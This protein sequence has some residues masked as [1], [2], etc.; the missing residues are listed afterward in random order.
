MILVTL[1]VKRGI[2]SNYKKR[3]GQTDRGRETETLWE[4]ISLPVLAVPG[5]PSGAATS[6]CPSVP[7]LSVVLLQAQGEG[8][9]EEEERKRRGLRM[10]HKTHKSCTKL[11]A[12]R[13]KQGCFPEAAASDWLHQRCVCWCV[14][15]GGWGVQDQAYMRTSLQMTAVSP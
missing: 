13:Y 10:T 1:L 9:R 15:R 11:I 3:E 7:R 8:K 6:L 14:C 5:Q 4:V 12:P 2:L